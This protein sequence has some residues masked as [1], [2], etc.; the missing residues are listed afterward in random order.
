[1]KTADFKGR[2]KGLFWNLRYLLKK[3]YTLFILGK[4]FFMLYRE[5]PNLFQIS[6]P[7]RKKTDVSLTKFVILGQTRSGTHLLC[8]LINAHPDVHCE[9]ELFDH[10]IPRLFLPE[11]FIEAKCNLF[12]NQSYG[13]IL[14]L[15]HIL[16]MK[17]L[18]LD[19]FLSQIHRNG[20]RIIHLHRRNVVRQQISLEIGKQ[21]GLWHADSENALPPQKY[22]IDPDVLLRRVRLRK[23]KSELEKEILSKCSHL[24][25]VYEDDLL[26]AEMHQATLNKVFE[27]LQLPSVP[28]DTKLARTSRDSLQDMILNYSELESIVINAGYGGYLSRQ[29]ALICPGRKNLSDSGESK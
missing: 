12:K 23:I 15:R 3:N 13:F 1:M 14:H 28:V 9:H 26:D 18:E 7:R 4:F 17:S 19:E 16:M 8:D 10:D 24:S 22:R 29:S 2:G 25:I 5:L 6:L 27:F 21:R 20:W 11:E